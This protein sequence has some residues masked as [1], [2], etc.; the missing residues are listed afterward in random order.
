MRE[1]IYIVLIGAVA[2]IVGCMLDV[3]DNNITWQECRSAVIGSSLIA[4]TLLAVI[5]TSRKKTT[6]HV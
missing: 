4:F 3:L 1:F 6:E 5:I 2:I